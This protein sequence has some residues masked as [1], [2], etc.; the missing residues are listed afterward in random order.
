MPVLFAQILTS[1]RSGEITLA[2]AILRYFSSSV[3]LLWPDKLK[4][5]PI[6]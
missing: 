1:G 4:G 3:A 2:G 6:L 5:L